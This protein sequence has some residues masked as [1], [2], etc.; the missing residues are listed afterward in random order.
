MRRELL[1]VAGAA[2]LALAAAA[3]GSSS[4]TTTSAGAASPGTS[5][6]PAAPPSSAPP[7]SA[8][9][10]VAAAHD[11]TGFGATQ[12]AW[13]T[14]HTPDPDKG[15]EFWNPDPALPKTTDGNVNDDYAG[16]TFTGGRALSYDVAFT[17]RSLQAAETLISKELPGDTKIVGSPQTQLHGLAGAQCVQVTYS[18]AQLAAV[19]GGP[20]GGTVYAVF[21]SWNAFHLDESTIAAT[22]LV[23]ENESEAGKSPC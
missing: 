8:A 5:S 10:A 9:P 22:S 11:L 6:T 19:V 18:S 1:A 23:S 13:S 2:V 3:C 20:H 4:P 14:K 21:Q 15:D 16:V 17:A 12:A 7:S